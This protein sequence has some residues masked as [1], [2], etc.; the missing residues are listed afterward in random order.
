VCSVQPSCVSEDRIIGL[1]E[2]PTL[3]L[4]N[5]ED[6]ICGLCVGRIFLEDVEVA[7]SLCFFAFGELTLGG[8]KGRYNREVAR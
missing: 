4:K 1:F 7:D 2:G 5:E 3:A 8:R 6:L